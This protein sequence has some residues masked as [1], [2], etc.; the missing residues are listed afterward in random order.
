[1]GQGSKQVSDFAA[2]VAGIPDGAVIAFGGFAAP[3]TPYN[4]LKALLA[5]GAKDLTCIANT[6]GGAHQPRM[7]DL[8][9][10]VENGQVRKVI[11]S[12]TAATRPTDV[13]PFTK[14]YESGEVEAE[15]VPQGTLAERL[16][17]GGMRFVIEP[18]VRFEGQV[19]EQA[20]MFF[21]DPSGNALEIKAFEDLSQVFAH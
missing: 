16:R 11:C 13:L 5:Q 20:T 4:L 14:Y 21:L 2:A 8:G 17:A 7:P 12:F 18:Q 3:G 10:L 9:M 1:M 15:L 19:G 6:T